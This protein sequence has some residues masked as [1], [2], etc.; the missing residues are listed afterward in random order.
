VPFVV[1]I[2]PSTG[3]IEM[4]TKAARQN[5][6]RYRTLLMIHALQLRDAANRTCLRED[7]AALLSTALTLETMAKG[8]HEEL[9]F[10]IAEH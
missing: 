3:G 7:R 9:A 1:I 5:Q 6:E 2:A 4:H 8:V 10:S